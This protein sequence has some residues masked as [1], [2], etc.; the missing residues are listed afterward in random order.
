M[1]FRSYFTQHFKKDGWAPDV[2][3]GR[4]KREGLYQPDEMVCTATLYNYIDDQ[5]LEIRNINLTDKL[6]R[7]THHKA[8]AKHKRTLGRSIDER[9]KSVENRLE[10][11]HYEL[12]TI[13]GKRNGQESVIMTFIERK[14]RFQIMRL[15]D[16]RDADSVNYAMR[17]IVSEYGSTIKSV[18]ADNGSE[19][20]DLNHVLKE[21]APVY[22]AHPYRSCERGTNEVHNRYVRRDFP[23]GQSLDLVSPRTVAA[24]EA[25][26]NRLPRKLLNYQT[27]EEVFL[28]E[29]N[30]A[31]SH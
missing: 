19:F 13:V 28:I 22:Y 21:T 8:L 3:V 17:D 31:L 12:D 18:T 6:R 4:A 9:P 5:L 20:A 15:I 30:S 11:G 29:S 1:L 2:A 16:G 23:S 24:V 7:R 27:T 14:S 25:K 26:L 10:F